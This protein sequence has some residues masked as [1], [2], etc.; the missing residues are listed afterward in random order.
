MFSWFFIIEWATWETM[1]S[2]AEES[3]VPNLVFVL[4]QMVSSSIVI[5]IFRKYSKS[6]FISVTPFLVKSIT[7]AE[8]TEKNQRGLK[9]RILLRE[10]REIKKL[11]QSIKKNTE[12]SE[13][14]K[15]LPLDFSDIEFKTDQDKMKFLEKLE[16][17]IKHLSAWIISS[18]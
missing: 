15:I 14:K 3:R 18:I 10:L 5:S 4:D 11:L 12:Q 13:S 16:A 9:M 6:R 17:L 7:Q 2:V 8:G 1:E